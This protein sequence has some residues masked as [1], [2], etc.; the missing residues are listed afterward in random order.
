MLLP[1]KIRLFVCLPCRLI[2]EPVPE[3][4]L[5]AW[6]DC[7]RYLCRLCHGY[8][9]A[10]IV[11]AHTLLDEPF[12]AVITLVNNVLDRVTVLIELTLEALGSYQD[13]FFAV[14]DGTPR[15]SL[16]ST[17]QK[18]DG[19]ALIHGDDL[20]R[21]HMTARFDFLHPSRGMFIKVMILERLS[22]APKG[23]E[24]AGRAVTWAD[25]PS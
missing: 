13:T 24:G 2:P 8:A 1:F 3:H 21:L 10:L 16:L 6:L 9:A 17:F 11:E 25:L 7:L 22:A 20:E 5:L 12:E 18:L 19:W 23:I 15:F 14:T 4:F